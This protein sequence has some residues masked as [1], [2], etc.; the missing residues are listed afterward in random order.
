MSQTPLADRLG[1]LVDLPVSE[2]V[3]H[4]KPML[5]LDRVTRLEEES[6]SCEWCVGEDGVFF[7]PG[8]GV[9]SYIGIE[10]MAQC[11]AV[12]GG[13]CERARGL[14]PP[15]GLL[16]G[17][18]RFQAQVQYFAGGVTYQA[19]CKKLISNAQGMSSYDCRILL[20]DRA[21]AQAVISVLQKPQGDFFN[22]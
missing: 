1:E 21:I 6:A 12:H 5:L 8:L 18:R 22:E 20:E 2:F 17:T 13:A 19:T 4:R 16:L 10:Y 7:I 3:L 11:M 14:P 9:P 15:R